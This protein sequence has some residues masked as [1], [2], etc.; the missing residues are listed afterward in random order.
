MQRIQF[1]KGIVE[2]S[3]VV[4][5]NQ[6]AQLVENHMAD[7]LGGLAADGYIDCDFPVGGSHSADVWRQQCYLHIG[8]GYSRIIGREDGPAVAEFVKN[9][10]FM[11]VVSRHT[12]SG[13]GF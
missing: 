1:V 9:S 2:L 8:T 4:E 3:A 12:S 11:V 6:V 5:M 13:F 7:D 10:F